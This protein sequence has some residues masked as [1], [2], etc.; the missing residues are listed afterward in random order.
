M[1]RIVNI[2]KTDQFD[3]FIGRGSKWGNPFAISN[4]CSREQAIVMYE[5]YIRQRPDL[6]ADLP[7]LLGKVLGCYRAPLPC[8]G[9]VLLKLMEERRLE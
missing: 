5:T 6:L 2:H 1:N 9:E 7:E 4:K 3:V 8:H